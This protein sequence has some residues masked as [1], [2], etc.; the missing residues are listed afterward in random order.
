MHIEPTTNLAGL[1]RPPQLMRTWPGK[2]WLAIAIRTSPDSETETA[3]PTFSR[4][5][6]DLGIQSKRKRSDW[7]GRAVLVE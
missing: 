4:P 6:L 1:G 2:G 5:P 7:L 3:H